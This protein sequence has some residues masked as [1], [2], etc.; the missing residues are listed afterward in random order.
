M[1]KILLSPNFYF[2]MVFLLQELANIRSKFKVSIL[3]P[4]LLLLLLLLFFILLIHF[5]MITEKHYIWIRT[6]LFISLYPDSSNE[7]QIF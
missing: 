7:K 4:K 2:M 5:K 6:R 3:L 1:E